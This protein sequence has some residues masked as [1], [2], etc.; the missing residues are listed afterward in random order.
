MNIRLDKD[1]RVR[2][3]QDDVSI[4]KSKKYLEQKFKVGLHNFSLELKFDSTILRSYVANEKNGIIIVLNEKD[5]TQ[6]CDISLSK[7]GI[8]IDDVAIQVDKWNANTRSKYEDH[9]KD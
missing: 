5:F 9:L 6:L 7:T 8:V 2:L 4:W 3:D 1:I